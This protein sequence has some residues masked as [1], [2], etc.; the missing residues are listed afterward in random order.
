M[1]PQHMRVGHRS[2]AADTVAIDDLICETAMTLGVDDP[3]YMKACPLPP[4][5]LPAMW[6]LFVKEPKDHSGRDCPDHCAEDPIE[7][8][9]ASMDEHGVGG[10]FLIKFH[11]GERKNP[12]Y[13]R[14][15]NTGLKDPKPPLVPEMPNILFYKA[16]CRIPIF[17]H[18]WCQGRCTIFRCDKDFKE[19]GGTRKVIGCLQPP[20]G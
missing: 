15:R 8:G 6:S 12:I 17:Y 14:L 3:E 9:D 5:C 7:G 10:Y 18:P 2:L 20:P 4:P 13:R 1:I 16:L 11:L 19:G